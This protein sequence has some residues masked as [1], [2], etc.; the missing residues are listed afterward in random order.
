MEKR[1]C[2][3]CSV[4]ARPRW[5][6]INKTTRWT[7]RGGL[8]GCKGRLLSPVPAAMLSTSNHGVTFT[9]TKA[10]RPSENHRGCGLK[11]KQFHIYIIIRWWLNPPHL[12]NM[13][14]KIGSCSP[15]SNTKKIDHR[16]QWH[17]LYLWMITQPH[18]WYV[19]ELSITLNSNS[20]LEVKSL[21][22]SC[23]ID[24]STTW[25]QVQG[26]AGISI[27]GKLLYHNSQ[28]QM[29]HVWNLYLYIWLNFSSWRFTMHNPWKNNHHFIYV[30]LWATYFWKG[31]SSKRF[32]QHFDK[33]WQQLP[34]AMLFRNAGSTCWFSASSHSFSFWGGNYSTKNQTKFTKHMAKTN[35]H[36]I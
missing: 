26:L 16:H 4:G 32:T 8:F 6:Y 27:M 24:Q 35:P 2:R 14:V 13:L 21:N 5:G 36:I 22:F 18:S 20:R 34:G 17:H 29:L 28:S 11:S 7:P 19:T 10:I 9:S 31:L 33:W 1:T 23:F 12:R 3:I 30:G 25:K 15:P